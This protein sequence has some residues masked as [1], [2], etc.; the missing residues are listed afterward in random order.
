M[1]LYLGLRMCG[2]FEEQTAPLP[3]CRSHHH[4]SMLQ[5]RGCVPEDTPKSEYITLH[6]PAPCKPQSDM[7]PSAPGHPSSLFPLP[8]SFT[9]VLQAATCDPHTN[10]PCKKCPPYIPAELCLAVVGKCRAFPEPPLQICH[11]AYL[12]SPVQTGRDYLTHL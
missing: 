4:M 9:P 11:I 3:C 5:L 7:L 8:G 2:G 10:T 1:H 12:G 6:R